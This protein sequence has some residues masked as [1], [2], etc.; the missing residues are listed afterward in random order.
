MAIR[1]ECTQRYT[2]HPLFIYEVND[3]IS[4]SFCLL[5]HRHS[6]WV[7]KPINLMVDGVNDTELQLS[8]MIA[9]ELIIVACPRNGVDQGEIMRASFSAIGL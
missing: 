3:P 5:V 1:T 9:N 4:L 8:E 7:N 2:K 6:L